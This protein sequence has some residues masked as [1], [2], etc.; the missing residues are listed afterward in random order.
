MKD[1]PPVIDRGVVVRGLNRCALILGALFMLLGTA[2][3]LFAILGAFFALL[4]R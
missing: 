1:S 2:L 4:S 3:L